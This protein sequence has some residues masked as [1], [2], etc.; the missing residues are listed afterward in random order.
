[1]CIFFFSVINKNE[2]NYLINVAGLDTKWIVIKTCLLN[3]TAKAF[4]NDI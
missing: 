4:C 1:M 2:T 3:S